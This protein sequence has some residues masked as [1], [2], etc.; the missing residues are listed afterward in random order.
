MQPSWLGPY[1]VR[2]F[3]SAHDSENRI[4]EPLTA[5]QLGF[6]GG[7]VPGV[8]VHAYM[9]HLPVLRWGREFLTRGRMSA[10]Y[11]S[12]VYDGQDAVIT[13]TEAEDTLA[14][15]AASQGRDCATGTASLAA[16]APV[17]AQPAPLPPPPANRP[18]ASAASLAPGTRLGIHPLHVTAERATLYLRDVRETDP[19]YRAEALIHP[20][21]LLRCCNWALLQNVR[22]GPWIHVSNTVQHLAPAAFGATLTLAATITANEV[23]KGHDMLD[24]DAVVMADDQPVCH[25]AYTAIWRPRQLRPSED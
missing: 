12:P 23:R 7:L 14:L 21:M 24:L 1:R 8:D 4:H 17:A 19:L 2:A 16:P 9:T 6:A 5:R 13:A 20:G 3:N 10:R 18:V 15:R 11:L 25:I 22:L